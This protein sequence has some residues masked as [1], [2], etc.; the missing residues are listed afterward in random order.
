M[1]PNY[2]RANTVVIFECY[3]N[4]SSEANT[5]EPSFEWW[6]VKAETSVNI[7]ELIFRWNGEDSISCKMYRYFYFWV[8]CCAKST[9]SKINWYCSHICRD[10]T[11]PFLIK[12]FR[13]LKY[14]KTF[15]FCFVKWFNREKNNKLLI[16][17]NNKSFTWK[18][19]KKFFESFYS[20]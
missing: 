18:V 5:P 6:W 9:D 4:H 10:W 1:E 17:S 3:V 11:F 16:F 2:R 20:D 7:L 12:A 14:R 13:S 15:Y 19:S 8:I